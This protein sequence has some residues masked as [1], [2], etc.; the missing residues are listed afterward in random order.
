MPIYE[1]TCD[2]CNSDFELR[3]AFSQVNSTALCP[4][5]YSEARRTISSFAAKTGSYLQVPEKPFRKDDIQK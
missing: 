1:Y 3:L 2:K 4:R 5:C